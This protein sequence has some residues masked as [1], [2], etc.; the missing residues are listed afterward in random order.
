MAIPRTRLL[1]AGIG[2]PAL[3]HALTRRTIVVGDPGLFSVLGRFAKGF[4]KGA[5]GLP[6]GR[7]APTP[8]PMFSPPAP[9]I[10]QR[11][12]NLL[13]NITPQQARTGGLFVAGTAGGLAA[14]GALGRAGSILTAGKNVLGGLLGGGGTAA[15]AVARGGMRGGRR[16]HM[17][18]TNVKAL[19]RATRRL[20]GF[21]RL[22]VATERS[23][24]HLV[25]HRRSH[26]RPR[27]K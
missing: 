18:A 4:V 1:M 17:R 25:R 15:G 9:T 10:T 20:A 3:C 5:A 2:D 12:L 22:A 23:L 11:A 8:T 7:A 26:A 13:P 6:I 24:G 19:R 16:R 27:R 14:G 21:H